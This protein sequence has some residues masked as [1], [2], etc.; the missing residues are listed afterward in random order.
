MILLNPASSPYYETTKAQA[1]KALA[2][3]PGGL[4]IGGG[5]HDENAEE[6]LRAGA[7]Q[8]IV[9]SFVF[10]DGRSKRRTLNRLVHAE[11]KNSWC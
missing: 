6:F 9:T 10:K 4:Q 8:V 2:A 5:I 1:M 11:E 7:S 3:W